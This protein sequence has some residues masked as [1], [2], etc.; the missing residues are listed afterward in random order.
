MAEDELGPSRSGTIT[1]DQLLAL[2][3]EIAALTRAGVPLERGLLIASRELRGRLG[4]I[5]GTLGRRL[6]RGEG[7]VEALEGEG[8]SIPPLYR[9]V[10]EAGA[11]SGQLPVALEGMAR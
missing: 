11:R 1:I 3:A 4:K 7:L 10:V 5:A 9:A 2:N 8:R 6:S